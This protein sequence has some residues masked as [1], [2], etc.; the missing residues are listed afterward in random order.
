MAEPMSTELTRFEVEPGLHLAFESVGSDP[1]T[2]IVPNTGIFP[3]FEPLAR[4]RR[5]VAL[6]SRGRGFSD[7]LLDP[8]RMGAE[9]EAEDI[10][11][12][13]R[14]L[15]LERM[16]LLGWSYVGFVT[17]LYAIRHPDR[18]SRLILLCSL[19]PFRD[20][21]WPSP[22]LPAEIQAELQKL[23][24][25]PLLVEDPEAACREFRRLTI[26][27]RMGD[28]AAF[29]KLRADP[30]QWEN[31]WPQLLMPVNQLVVAPI[32][33]KD[34]RS[35]L[36]RIQAPTLVIHGDAD[37]ITLA[38]SEAW[39]RHIADARLLRLPGVGHFPAAECPD[40]LFPALEE[41]LAGRWPAGAEK[42]S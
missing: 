19:P 38:G 26:P 5:V 18:V 41:F 20:P 8:D 1:E 3:D 24:E 29:E 16:P 40:L 7:R 6:H 30:C 12:L 17:A 22:A 34:I 31:E 28:P 21:A 13:R 2:L 9:V 37:Q 4:G 35:E 15:G 36:S 42:V 14:H 11:S 32:Q 27:Y 10:E 25:S 39:A 23:R 33:E